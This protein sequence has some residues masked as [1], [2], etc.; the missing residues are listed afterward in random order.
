M[1]YD[2]PVLDKLN[3][4][5]I[6]MTVLLVEVKGTGEPTFWGESGIAGRAILT[7]SVS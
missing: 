4:L 3:L 1:S 6:V 5:M 7:E 2:S